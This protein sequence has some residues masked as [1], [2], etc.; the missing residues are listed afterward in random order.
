MSAM[1]P[2]IGD[3]PLCPCQDGDACHYRD[4]PTAKGWD[5]TDKLPEPVADM[6]KIFVTIEV[7]VDWPTRLD[8]QHILEREIHADR[9][10][11]NWP[12]TV[13]AKKDAEIANLKT[14]MIA[15]AEEIAAH[16]NAHCDAEGYGPANLMHRLERGIA[17]EYGY[18]AGNWARMTAE[19]NALRAEN[20]ALAAGQCVN[21]TADDGGTPVCAE[22][23]ALRAEVEALRADAERYRWL[24][25]SAE[26]N[27]IAGLFRREWDAAIDAARQDQRD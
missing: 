5:V 18:T 6:R 15:A 22:I 17:A 9:W 11:W 14:T 4:T 8:M 23:I 1:R 19:R 12:D 13:I 16:W 21:A 7:P 26:G 20:F 10:S 27:Q 3:D 2:C 25:D 24:R